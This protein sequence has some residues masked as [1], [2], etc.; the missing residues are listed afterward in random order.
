MG[1]L[2]PSHGEIV[3]GDLYG[4]YPCFMFFTEDPFGPGYWPAP[5]AGESCD[6]DVVIILE[7]KTW[8]KVLC[9]FGITFLHHDSIDHGRRL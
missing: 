4:L 9:R 6:E 5:T 8:I 3:I 1:A 2:Q 7:Y